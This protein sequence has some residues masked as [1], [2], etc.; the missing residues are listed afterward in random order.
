MGNLWPY[1]PGYKMVTGRVEKKKHT[2]P[3]LFVPCVRSNWADSFRQKSP[4]SSTSLLCSGSR[5]KEWVVK[6]ERGLEEKMHK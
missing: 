4:I 5:L 3:M 2:R 6:R 1:N